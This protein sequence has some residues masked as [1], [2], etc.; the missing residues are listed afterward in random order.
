MAFVGGMLGAGGAGINPLA[1]VRSGSAR[2]AAVR[3]Y[4]RAVSAFVLTAPHGRCTDMLAHLV[5]PQFLEERLLKAKL[6][7]VPVDEGRFWDLIGM[8]RTERYF[9]DKSYARRIHRDLRRL[10]GGVGV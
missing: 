4:R 2:A 9:D 6:Y 10:C 7:G 8:V 1:K 5:A 3:E